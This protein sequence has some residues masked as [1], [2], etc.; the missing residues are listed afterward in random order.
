M[1]TLQVESEIFRRG[2]CRD[3]E[4]EEAFEEYQRRMRAANKKKS[5][6]AQS[7][8]ARQPPRPPQQ[9]PPTSVQ[10]VLEKEHDVRTSLR[11]RLEEREHRLD[12]LVNE[13]LSSTGPSDAM[14]LSAPV[15]AEQLAAELKSNERA[16]QA[17]NVEFVA[18]Y[19]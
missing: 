2:T 1:H 13:K 9:P 19:R 4:E 6:A 7:S 15:S 16:Q 3:V 8:S 5:A 18:M 11:E 10:A 12:A 17:E 14:Q